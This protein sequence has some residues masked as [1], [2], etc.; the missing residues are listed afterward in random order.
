ML[1][2]IHSILGWPFALITAS[3][4]HGTEVIRLFDSLKCQT[5]LLGLMSI[6]FLL[7]TLRRVSVG[8]RSDQFG[9][10]STVTPSSL[11]L[12]HMLDSFLTVLARVRLKFGRN[13]A[14][15]TPFGRRLASAN[16]L[17]VKLM[18]SV[19]ATVYVIMCRQITESV[20]YEQFDEAVLFAP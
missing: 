17:V 12:L 1:T 14:W 2:F 13:H 16:G 4:R 3:M 9:Q 8:F 19:L 18:L 11:K 10:S 20:F 6:I 15:I 5:G 7:T